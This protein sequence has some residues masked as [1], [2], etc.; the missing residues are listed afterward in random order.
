MDSKPPNVKVYEACG[1][2]VRLWEGAWWQV[3]LKPGYWSDCPPID[4]DG[5]ALE[6]LK[7]WLSQDELRFYVMDGTAIKHTVTIGSQHPSKENLFGRA[8]DLSLAQAICLALVAASEKGE[9]T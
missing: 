4:T 3:E 9:G 8:K 6:L 5:V 2:N 7:V 1:W